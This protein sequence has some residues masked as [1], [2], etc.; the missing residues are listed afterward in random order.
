M[1]DRK[2]SG[3]SLTSTNQSAQNPNGQRDTMAGTTGKFVPK[4]NEMHSTV[5]TQVDPCCNMGMKGPPHK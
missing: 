1:H 4:G 2:P 3:D 5:Q